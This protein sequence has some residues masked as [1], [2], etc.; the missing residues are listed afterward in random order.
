MITF[1]VH[2]LYMISP[3]WDSGSGAVQQASC[4]IV[5]VICKGFKYRFS[6]TSDLRFSLWSIVIQETVQRTVFLCW[7]NLVALKTKEL[8]LK[9]S[10]DTGQE[11]VCCTCNQPRNS[12]L[13]KASKPFS[14]EKTR[15]P[16]R[17]LL[18]TKWLKMMKEQKQ[19]LMQ[20]Q[21][22]HFILFICP[23]AFVSKPHP[24]CWRLIIVCIRDYNS[25]QNEV[26]K[27]HL[28]IAVAMNIIIFFKWRE[29]KGHNPSQSQILKGSIFFPRVGL[30]SDAI[31]CLFV[32]CTMHHVVIMLNTLLLSLSHRCKLCPDKK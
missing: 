28:L 14:F 2:T 30:V 26:Y 6:V 8:F 20:K 9:G 11:L 19:H 3:G 31:F 7:W 18:F 25:F 5:A 16:Q 10:N 24:W 27:L 15:I 23:Y 4:R 13:L 17:K 32:V 22:Q 29:G 12:V 21:Q 1:H